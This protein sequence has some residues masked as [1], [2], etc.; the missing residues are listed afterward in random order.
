MQMVP[1]DSTLLLVF[2]IYGLAFFSLGITLSI[3]SGRFPVLAD[4]KV[5][6]PLAFFGLIHGTHEWLEAYL[7]QAEGFGNHYPGWMAWVRLS[8]LISSFFFLVIFGLQAFR[9]HP[10]KYR[11]GSIL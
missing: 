2:F 7:L 10:P 11:R 6:R 9:S 1:F 4:A 3:E 5:L 8:L